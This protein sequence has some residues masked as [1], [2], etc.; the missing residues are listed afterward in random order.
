MV[1][2]HVP[3]F[4][5][6]TNISADGKTLTLAAT[7]SVTGINVGGTVATN[8][9]TSSTFRIKVP[10]VL[11]LEK[12]GIFAKLPKKIYQIVDFADSNLIIQNKLEIKY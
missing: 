12:S 3:V 10:K 4:N 6:V 11:N 1:L 8:K 7:T 5:K 2:N 9:T